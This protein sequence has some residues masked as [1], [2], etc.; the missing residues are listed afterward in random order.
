MATLYFNNISVRNVEIGPSNKDEVGLKF[1]ILDLN[2][3]QLLEEIP[4]KD[5]VEHLDN[6]N[7]L[8]AE[9][10]LKRFSLEEIFDEFEASELKE[11]LGIIPVSIEMEEGKDSDEQIKEL[12]LGVLRAVREVHDK[13]LNV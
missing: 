3:D 12:Y 7:Q 13:T 4:I 1:S 10:F 6:N 5:M 2:V 8:N 9:F 11:K